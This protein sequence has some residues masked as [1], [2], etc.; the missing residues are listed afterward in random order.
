MGKDIATIVCMKVELMK[1]APVENHKC[2]NCNCD[3][4]ITSSSKKKIDEV[5]EKRF[6]C[7]ECFKKDGLKPGDTLA[8]LDQN[9]KR[10]ILKAMRAR[11]GKSFVPK[12][13]FIINYDILIKIFEDDAKSIDMVQ[14]M[15]EMKKANMKFHAVTTYPCFM[16]AIWQAND[17]AKIGKIKDIMEL[18]DIGFIREDA[19]CTFQ[20]K[21]EKYIMDDLMQTANKFAKNNSKSE[22]EDEK[23]MGNKSS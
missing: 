2:F 3:V 17:D 15:F 8:P 16:R 14:K 23:D 10:E 4:G 9:Q 12:P 18:L 5:T 6:I 13:I 7:V 1:I 22:E 11:F 20:Y 21:D 19:F